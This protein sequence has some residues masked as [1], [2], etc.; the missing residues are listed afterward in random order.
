LSGRRFLIVDDNEFLRAALRT[1]LLQAGQQ[2][3]GEARDGET[4]LEK[5]QLLKPDVV[6]L[7]VMMPGKN[8]LEVL[9]EI[10][11]Q[12]PAMKVIVITAHSEREIIHQLL[13]AGAD[14]M[15]LKPFTLARITAAITHALGA[16][17]R[18]SV[19]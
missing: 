19:A 1:V 8:G 18:N 10:K 11:D 17:S 15:V 13:D 12:F 4:A 7:D 14:S 6:C 2:V 16:R 3:V 9:R 5:A